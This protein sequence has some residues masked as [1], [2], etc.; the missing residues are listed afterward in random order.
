MKRKHLLILLLTVLCCMPP[1]TTVVA[2]GTTSI[3]WWVVAGG[4]GPVSVD[5][6]IVLNSTLGQPIIGPSAVPPGLLGELAEP[7]RTGAGYWYGIAVENVIYLP[8]VLCSYGPWAP[9]RA[10][11]SRLGGG[12][13][14][15]PP[16]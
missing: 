8:V 15:W 11:P 6:G 9:R 5:G 1:A 10:P 3:D 7:T 14:E 13:G 16:L 2:Q 12:T 4:G